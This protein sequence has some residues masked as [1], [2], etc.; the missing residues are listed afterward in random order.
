MLCR[1]PRAVA[2][3]LAYVVDAAGV[4]RRRQAVLLQVG[5]HLV[6]GAIGLGRQAHDDDGGGGL[7]QVPQGGVG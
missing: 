3:G 5:G 6:A 4:A 7:Q 2:D 1:S